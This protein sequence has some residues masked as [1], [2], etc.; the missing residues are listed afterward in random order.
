MITKENMFV[1]LLQV[2]DG[3]KPEWD[4]FESEWQDEGPDLPLYLIMP[5]LARYM[6]KLLEQGSEHE[7]R[8]IFSV[9][10]RWHVEGDAYVSEAATI[11][12]LEDLQNIN[13]VKDPGVPDRIEMYLLPESRKMWLKLYE[14]W[15][16]GSQS[17]KK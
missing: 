4:A 5:A 9:I 11:G 17:R 10:E 8:S 3:F 16:G 6:V 15:N 2:A 7:L 14:F 1:P 12:I 13:I